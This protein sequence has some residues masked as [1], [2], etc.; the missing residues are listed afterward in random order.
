[1]KEQLSS[2]PQ[3]R[4]PPHARAFRVRRVLTVGA[5]ALAAVVAGCAS[6]SPKPEEIVADRAKARWALML[7]G[8]VKSAYE[9]LAPSVR[10]LLPADRYVSRFGAAAGLDSAS[11]I[12][13]SCD[14]EVRC[15]ARIRVERPPILGGRK[16]D[17]I[18]TH[19]DETWVKED[20]QWW[21]FI[22]L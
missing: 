18:S 21:L 15:T 12:A 2:H 22:R 6:I 16:G 13:S 7:D 9:Y 19:F 3:K 5:V 1:M 17:K 10:K 20:G 11:V 4:T 14:S 8:D